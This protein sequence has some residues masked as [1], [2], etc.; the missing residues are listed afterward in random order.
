LKIRQI[1]QQKPW[2]YRYQVVS[3]AKKNRE[4]DF[5]YIA[6]GISKLYASCS[7]GKNIDVNENNFWYTTR[8]TSINGD[9]SK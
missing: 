7:S 6:F 1:I 9:I 5:W 8:Q 2:K 4:E 3:R